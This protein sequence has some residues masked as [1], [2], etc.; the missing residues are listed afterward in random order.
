MTPNHE[1]VALTLDEFLAA[2]RAD[3]AEYE[4]ESGL[5]SAAERALFEAEHVRAEYR[6]HWKGRLRAGLRIGYDA[7]EAEL[8]AELEAEGWVDPFHRSPSAG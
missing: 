5:L 6:A 8:R 2:G 4:R 1:F 7:P 3:A